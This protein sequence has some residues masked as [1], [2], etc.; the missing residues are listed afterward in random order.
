[1]FGWGQRR[2]NVPDAPKTQA[3][4]RV[5]AIG[6]VHGRHDLLRVLMD[7]LEEHNSALPPVET[8]HIVFLGDLIDR[9]PHAADV[10][11]FVYDMEQRFEQII[12][13]LGNHEEMLLRALSGEATTLRAWLRTG[14]HATLRSF[15][16]E[17]EPDEEPAQLIARANAAIPREWIEWLRQRPLTARSGDYFFCHAG[18]RP[19][20]ALHRQSRDDLLWIRD[21]FLEDDTG[22]GAVIVHGHS[23][24]NDVEIRANRIGID[25]GAYRTGVL[26]ALYL[27]GAEREIIST[28]G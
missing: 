23:V 5:Y 12:V 28:A 27:D 22:H 8:M 13:L 16:I 26:T 19:G 18:I 17:P 24:A 4:E 14:G 11:R 15:G 21:Q 6:D 7:K 9:G 20:R 3:G 1:M 25:T 2:R 10:M